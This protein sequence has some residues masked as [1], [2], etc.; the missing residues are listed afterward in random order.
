MCS[1]PLACGGRLHNQPK[2]IDNKPTY[3]YSKIKCVYM[4]Q[5][6]VYAGFRVI[7][8]SYLFIWGFTSHITT[9]AFSFVDRGNQYIELVKVFYC[10]LL[11]I[12]KEVPAFPHKVQDLNCR[13]QR[14]EANVLPLSHRGPLFICLNFM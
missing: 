14:W 13:P 9:C 12:G 10:K 2:T 11:T 6:E 4:D 7:E 1:G 5:I 3:M 8:A